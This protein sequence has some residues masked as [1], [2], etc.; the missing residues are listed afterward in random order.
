M[1]AIF[2]FDIEGEGKWYVDL[3]NGS[4]SVGKGDPQEK[5]DVT[6]VLNK[7]VLLKMFNSK[8]TEVGSRDVLR[9]AKLASLERLKDELGPAWNVLRTRG[10]FLRR[11]RSDLTR[12]LSKAK[13]ELGST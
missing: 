5:P 1:N 2:V 6:L 12:S 3:K 8:R 7:D 10:R 11:F 4:G 13:S 9:R